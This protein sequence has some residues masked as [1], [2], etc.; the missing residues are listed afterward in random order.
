M[1][2]KLGK[3]GKKA[4]ALSD[5]ALG[6]TL[7]YY[8]NRTGV[9]YKKGPRDKQCAERS[10]RD[11]RSGKHGALASR[12]PHLPDLVPL[13]EIAFSAAPRAWGQSA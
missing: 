6:G 7:F 1:G 5:K 8:T 3:L 11:T 2:P 9:L 12:L 4:R 13:H 10:A